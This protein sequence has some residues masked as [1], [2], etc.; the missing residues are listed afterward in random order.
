MIPRVV[1][2][3]HVR[4]VDLNELADPPAGGRIPH[5]SDHV[6]ARRQGPGRIL[7]AVLD[8]RMP[9]VTQQ[10]RLVGGDGVLTAR[11]PVLGVD[12]KDLHRE[13]CTAWCPSGS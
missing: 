11:L 6:A 9:G 1:D 13:E 12:L 7:L 3:G 2:V 10:L 5:C 4:P 8:D